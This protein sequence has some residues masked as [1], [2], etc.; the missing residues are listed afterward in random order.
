V[1]LDGKP[2]SRAL[3][4]DLG[5]VAGKLEHRQTADICATVLEIFAGQM[6][7]ANTPDPLPTVTPN[8]EDLRRELTHP[9]ERGSAAAAV[10]RVSAGMSASVFGEQG[11][12]PEV[13][14]ATLVGKRAGDP[15]RD[16]LR[17]WAALIGIQRFDFH[18]AGQ[19]PRGSIA[20][21]GEAIAI[22]AAPNLATPMDAAERF[23]LARHLWRASSGFGVFQ[24]GDAIRPVRWVL[25][26]AAAVL[27]A[28]A[29][30]PLPTDSELVAKATDTLTRKLRRQ[31]DAPCQQLVQESPQTIKNWI[32]ASSY[33]ADRFGLIAAGELPAVLPA[34]VEESAGPPGLR[35]LS[36]NAEEAIGKVPRGRELLRFTL[37][38]GYLEL[39][40]AI[41]LAEEDGK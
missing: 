24:E 31:L 30:L 27:G 2:V 3:T 28:D 19:D 39:R 16:W 14:R 37:A 29:P 17:T 20:I 23:F 9:S 7:P 11:T 15:V 41:G 35:R 12:F 26:V 6:G 33:S 4:S 34:L 22:A 32:T 25:A 40:R 10:L 18:R 8:A 5:A 36:E 1:S 38:G 21:P 13:G